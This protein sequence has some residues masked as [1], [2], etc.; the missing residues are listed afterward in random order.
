M[1]S[2]YDIRQ[3]TIFIKDEKSE[4]MV[5][6]GNVEDLTLEDARQEFDEYSFDANCVSY[7]LEASVSCKLKTISRKKFI[8]LLMSRKI[9]RNAANALA[10][11]FFNKRGYYLYIDLY[12][13]DGGVIWIK[14]IF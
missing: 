5:K 11:Y 6:L 2:E 9:Q 13:V 7:P 1:M 4:E 3:T 8:K 14:K 10:N 12:L